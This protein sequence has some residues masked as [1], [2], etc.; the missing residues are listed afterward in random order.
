MWWARLGTGALYA[1][2]LHAKGDLLHKR[3]KIFAD[4]S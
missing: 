1:W 3:I 2:V 4:V